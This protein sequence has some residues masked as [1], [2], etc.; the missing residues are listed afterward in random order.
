[1][2]LK[3]QGFSFVEMVF[4]TL[5]AGIIFKYV[6]LITDKVS[7]HSAYQH[8]HLQLNEINLALEYFYTEKGYWPCPDSNED[9]VEDV[10][11][12]GNCVKGDG[13]LPVISLGLG[14]TH[15]AWGSP[16]YYRVHND[17]TLPQ[18]VALPC[19][20]GS[21][22]NHSGQQNPTELWE[23]SINNIRLC[24]AKPPDEQATDAEVEICSQNWV[25]AENSQNKFSID[26]AA[27]PIG[28]KLGTG[29]FK[30]ANSATNQIQ[31]GV[32][33]VVI[34]WGENGR[35]LN[36]KSCDSF[37]AKF[38]NKNELENCDG[39]RDFF[40]F[41]SRQ[42]PDFLLWLDVFQAKVLKAENE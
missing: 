5:I 40:L 8:I 34:S 22:F 37:D 13:D 16:F 12:G 32:V 11:M 14:F 29:S 39:D 1:M 36:I 28:T 19:S 23:C 10:A 20:M 30:I 21:V 24:S 42:A 26:Y 9:G 17:A 3:Q 25:L 27:L 18:N 33:G 2:P 15:D 6:F 35:N 38:L 41:E 31:S 7:Q 4:V